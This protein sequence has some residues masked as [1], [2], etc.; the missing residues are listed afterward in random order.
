[1]NDEN[2]NLESANAKMS[3]NY[4]AKVK[5][6]LYKNAMDLGVVAR[7]STPIEFQA[8]M[9]AVRLEVGGAAD[10]KDGESLRY[11]KYFYGDVLIGHITAEVDYT[12]GDMTVSM[13]SIHFKK[14]IR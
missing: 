2:K 8:M 11:M 14:P 3:E 13:K 12:A 9:S 4:A 5:A 7:T 10:M 1:M 6:Y